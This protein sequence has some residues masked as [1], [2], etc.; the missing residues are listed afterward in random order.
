MS[1]PGHQPAGWPSGIPAASLVAPARLRRRALAGLLDSVIMLSVSVIVYLVSSLFNA[2]TLD[3]EWSRQYSLNPDLLPNVPAIHVDLNLIFATSVGIAIGIVIYAALSW[4]RLGGLPGQLAMGMRILDFDTGRQLGFPAALRRSVV[5][6]APVGA[7]M[8]GTALVTFER[9]ATVPMGENGSNLSPYGIPL[10]SPLMPWTDAIANVLLLGFGWVL[11]LALTTAIGPTK[12][13]LQDLFAGSI[14]IGI[15]RLPRY[16]AWGPYPYPNPYPGAGSPPGIGAG[17]GARPAPGWTPPGYWTPP[18]Q[19]VPPNWGQPPGA[20]PAGWPPDGSPGTPADA[21]PGTPSD[22]P[23]ELQ[24]DAPSSPPVPPW[25]AASGID[26][27]AVRTRPGTLESATVGRRVSAYMVDSFI[28]FMLFSSIVAAISPNAVSGAALTDER[29]SIFAGLAGG[30]VQLAYFVLG[31]RFWRAT[32]GQK[33]MGISVV[34]ESDG[35]AMSAM[36]ALVRWAVVQG[37]FA[38]VT[39][40]PLAVAPIVS[41]GAACWS[42]FLLYSTQNDEGRQGIHDHFLGTRVVDS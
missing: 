1:G 25:K 3:A 2:W 6:Y 37:P 10:D 36:D 32:L 4:W 39:I 12:R 8:C 26:R 21:P 23:P 14:A 29:L 13:G 27:P 42:A 33:L 17:E 31:W 19:E 38:L 40:V 15:Q 20:P 5:I 11:L 16:A 7:V 9:F 30:A 24:P 34:L 28:V 35:K 22:A 41:F 18:G